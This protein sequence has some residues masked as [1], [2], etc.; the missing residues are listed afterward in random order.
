M[1]ITGSINQHGKIQPIGGVNEKIEGFFDL[2]KARGLT[3]EQGVLIPKP[4]VQHLMLRHDV[5]EAASQ[6]EF[7][8]YPVDTIEQCLELLSDLPAGKRDA[9]GNYPESSQ[10]QSEGRSTTQSDDR[11]ATQLGPGRQTRG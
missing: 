1:A 9:E 10:F 3:G 4:N 8:I 11:D 5:V 7:H 2:C 6:G